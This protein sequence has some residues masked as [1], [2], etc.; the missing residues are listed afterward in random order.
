MRIY[1]TTIYLNGI[2]MSRG[3]KGP[4]KETN[5]FIEGV[6]T[7]LLSPNHGRK[8]NCGENCKVIWTIAIGKE[9][10]GKN[11]FNECVPR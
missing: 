9:F 11:N 4:T 5:E 8:H 7:D 3:R 2:R 6:L 10:T 1:S